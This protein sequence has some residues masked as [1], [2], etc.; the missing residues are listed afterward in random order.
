[1]FVQSLCGE[2]VAEGPVRFPVSPPARPRPVRTVRAFNQAAWSTASGL[3]SFFLLS[4]A[5]AVALIHVK[6]CVSCSREP[7]A[8]AGPS[9]LSRWSCA[10]KSERGLS[11]AEYS[12]DIYSTP[13]LCSF[14]T[15]C[16]D[17]AILRS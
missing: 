15:M 3:L 6:P 4:L 2:Q 14:M 10:T 1:M 8:Q 5:A 12:T 11:L 7:G 13:E 9:R 17:K 16:F